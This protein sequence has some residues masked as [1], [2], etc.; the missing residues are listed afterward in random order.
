MFL[1][2]TSDVL[3]AFGFQSVQTSCLLVVILRVASLHTYKLL[4]VSPNRSSD[5]KMKFSCCSRNFPTGYRPLFGI[6][7]V[8]L[9]C[10]DPLRLQQTAIKLPDHQ[11]RPPRTL[12]TDWDNTICTG[13][14]CRQ[15]VV[16]GC[17]GCRHAATK[18]DMAVTRGLHDHARL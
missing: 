16:E 18:T 14:V 2:F 7:S 15:E 10:R 3:S 4:S 17:P 9:F 8:V 12:M 11:T 5:C 13:I 6:L 1:P